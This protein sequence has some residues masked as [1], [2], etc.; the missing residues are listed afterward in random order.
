MLDEKLGLLHEAGRS[1]ALKYNS[2]FYNFIQSCSPKL[3]DHGKGLV[4]KFGGRVSAL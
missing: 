1:L 4:E 3:Y 2:R